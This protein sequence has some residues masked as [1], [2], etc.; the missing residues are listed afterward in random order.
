MAKD[1][2]ERIRKAQDKVMEH[3]DYIL[4][5]V[6]TPDFVEIVGR[7]DGDIVTYR[8]Y[9]DGSEY[10]KWAGRYFRM[11]LDYRTEEFQKVSVCGIVCDFSDM[12]IDRS[13]VPKERYQYEVADDDESQGNPVRV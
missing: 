8:V 2:S 4:E 11:R 3:L 9:D 12:R 6:P 13:T 7:V 1:I 10:G 5:T